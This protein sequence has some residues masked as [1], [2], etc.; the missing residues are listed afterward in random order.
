MPKYFYK[1][2]IIIMLSD[3]Q[4]KSL[5]AKEKHY[6]TTDDT[7]RRGYGRLAVRTYP[8]GNKV[9]YLLYTF[10]KKRKYLPLG[11]YPTMPLKSARKL[12]QNYGQLIFDGHDPREQIEQEL[13]KAEVARELA[14]V[15]LLEGS[16]GEMF[17]LFVARTERERSSEYY[18]AIKR[19]LLGD[20]LK[21]LGTDTKPN[22]ITEDHILSVIRPIVGRGSLV[23][24]NRA[25]SYLHAAFAFGIEYDRSTTRPED[26]VLFNLNHNPVSTIAKT[27]KKE[28]VSDR[29]L[30]GDELS[31]FWK[32]IE[33][34][35]IAV[36][37]KIL[38]KLLIVFG[39]RRVN[40]VI[41]APWSEFDLE[42]ATWDRPANRDKKGHSAVM[43]LGKKALEL[44]RELHTI[45]EHNTY[46]FGDKPPTDYAVNQTVKRLI[47]GRMEHFTPKNLRATAKTL[48][49]SIGISKEN[50]DRYH[51]HALTDVSSVHY[52]KYNYL[53]ENKEVVRR[54][55]LYLNDTL[56]GLEHTIKMRIIA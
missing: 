13:A 10:K 32:I 19:L 46:L 33:E 17:T 35:Q 56:K 50:R 2:F 6:Y 51:G 54:W 7:G 4:I 22:T 9:F 24:A 52:D 39:G 12:S 1:Y 26:G 28:P 34:S 23:M 8:N 25:R 55:E 37:R 53:A 38:L 11:I 5:Q 49:G 41:Q 20:A 29:A 15:K 40:E 36:E 21:I 42:A 3:K 44:L 18:K 45:T 47:N 16:V 48:M 43:P 30:S 27:L 31:Q 14:R